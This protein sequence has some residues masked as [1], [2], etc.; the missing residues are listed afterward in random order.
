[1]AK[2]ILCGC[3]G[4]NT[5]MTKYPSQNKIK[6]KYATNPT[7]RQFYEQNVQRM[8]NYLFAWVIPQDSPIKSPSVRKM[9]VPAFHNTL[10]DQR[11]RVSKPVWSNAGIKEWIPIPDNMEHICGGHLFECVI[12]FDALVKGFVDKINSFNVSNHHLTEDESKV[13]HV[14]MATSVFT[15]ALATTQK[16]KTALEQ[17]LTTKQQLI[18]L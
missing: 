9:S 18:S 12:F 3:Y 10:M 4:Y 1:M 14:S 17:S 11:M 8:H 6:T 16:T 7:E 15:S 2:L 5:D 13:L